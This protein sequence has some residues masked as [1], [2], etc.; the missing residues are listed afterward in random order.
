MTV[1]LMK[2]KKSSPSHN[3]FRLGL[4]T[5][6]LGEFPNLFLFHVFSVTMLSRYFKMSG[7]LLCSLTKIKKIRENQVGFS[8][9]FP[10]K[11]HMD[12]TQQLLQSVRELVTWCP[13]ICPTTR[14]FVLTLYK[15]DFFVFF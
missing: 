2:L 1:T 4:F 6:L 13:N 15:F 5:I 12:I 8:F 14:N 3:F 9:D 10:V 11:K 7:F